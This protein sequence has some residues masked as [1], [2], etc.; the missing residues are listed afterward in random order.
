M[1]YQIV[2]TS[3]ETR[4][5]RPQDLTALLKE[6]RTNNERL[7]VTGL[8]LYRKGTFIQVLEGERMNVKDLYDRIVRDERHQGVSQLKAGPVDEREFGE[9]AMGFRELDEDAMAKLSDLEGYSH[10]L[11]PDQTVHQL[12]KLAQNPS[13]AYEALLLF[14]GE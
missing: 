1:P 11:D 12:Q 4:K 6:A 3:A 10:F 2:Y 7:G 8:L 13:Y 9:W 14:K 5:M